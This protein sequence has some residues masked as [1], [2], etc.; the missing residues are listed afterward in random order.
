MRFQSIYDNIQSAGFELIFKDTPAYSTTHKKGNVDTDVVFEIMKSII[1][2]TVPHKILIIS[3]DGDYI[4][5]VTY[6]IQ[7]ERFSKILLP[8][9]RYASKL[10]T[11][12]EQKYY[13]FIQNIRHKVEYKNEKGP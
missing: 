6:L 1:E 8:N 2:R 12:L 9:K 13:D 10:Y 5:T 11:S 3:G 4:K 7:K